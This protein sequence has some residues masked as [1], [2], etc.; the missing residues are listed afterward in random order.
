MPTSNNDRLLQLFNQ[1]SESDKNSALDFMEY[2]IARQPS[3]QNEIITVRKQYLT[4]ATIFLNSLKTEHLKSMVWFFHGCELG[5]L[6]RE[7]QEATKTEDIDALVEIRRKELELQNK[8]IMLL[9][10]KFE[11]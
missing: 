10:K 9:Q 1:L 3:H 6:V 5:L 8:G 7:K 4:Q 11:E 2:L